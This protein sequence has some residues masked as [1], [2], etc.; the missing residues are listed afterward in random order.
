MRGNA[1]Q[2]GSS[3]GSLPPQKEATLESST[4]KGVEQIS[5]N[6]QSTEANGQS[7]SFQPANPSND[8][9][10]SAFDAFDNLATSR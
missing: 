3:I 9:A 10:V 6:S 7:E 2:S 1:I 8:E 4:T 5:Q